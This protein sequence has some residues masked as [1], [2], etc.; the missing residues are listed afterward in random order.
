MLTKE[1][2]QEAALLIATEF[3]GEDDVEEVKYYAEEI[4]ATRDTVEQFKT[5][6]RYSRSQTDGKLTVLV[7]AQR[8]KGDDRQDVYIVDFGDVRAVYN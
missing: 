5:N 7:D 8:I 1:Q 6:L 4:A 2:I 3:G